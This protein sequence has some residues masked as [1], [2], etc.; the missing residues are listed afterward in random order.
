MIVICK[1]Q[2]YCIHFT[3]THTYLHPHTPPHT[4]PSYPV[5]W[6]GNQKSQSVS[7]SCPTLCDP[8]DCSRPGSSVQGILQASILE[9]VAIPFS[10]GSSWPRDQTQVSC[11][12]Y[13]LPSEHQG[14]PENKTKTIEKFQKTENKQQKKTNNKT[15][16]ED[17]HLQENTENTLQK[18]I[19]SEQS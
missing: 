15:E 18:V 10:R 13:C 16:Q 17:W 5:S 12:V 7:Q 9:W 2:I 11:T 1:M 19:F 4:H 3:Q 14:S 8:K 6:A